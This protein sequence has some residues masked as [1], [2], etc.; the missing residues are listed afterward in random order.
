MDPD[1][2]GL[3]G[4]RAPRSKQPFMVTFFRASP[5]P[6]RAPRAVRPLR[7]RLSKKTNE[8]PQPNKLPGIFG[9]VWGWPGSEPTGFWPRTSG[10]DTTLYPSVGFKPMVPLQP[11]FLTPSFCPMPLGTNYTV[12]KASLPPR[13]PFSALPWLTR[14]S[15]ESLPESRASSSRQHHPWWPLF[16]PQFPCGMHSGLGEGLP[17]SLSPRGSGMVLTPLRAFLSCMGVGPLADLSVS[18]VTCGMGVAGE[19]R[20]P[21][22][23]RGEVP[24]EERRRCRSLMAEG[25][26]GC[27]LEHQ[28]AHRLKVRGG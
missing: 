24:Q 23:R 15:L 8:L 9:E 18:Y 2:A 5:S 27:L 3:L 1:L 14:P 22:G 17:A 11:P 6:V 4:Q 12:S 28:E 16:L 7:K 26:Q 25:P 10:G 20:C 13:S 19:V 21:C